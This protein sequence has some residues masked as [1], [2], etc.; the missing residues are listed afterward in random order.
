MYPN[1]SI[2][3]NSILMVWIWWI[4]SLMSVLAC[5]IP[6]V[7]IALGILFTFPSLSFPIHKNTQKFIIIHKTWRL[8][9]SQM[10]MLCSFYRCGCVLGPVLLMCK[11]W[12]VS[13][14]G[15]LNLFTIL[16]LGCQERGQLLTWHHGGFCLFSLSSPH[17]LCM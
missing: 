6:Y 7:C 9:K 12:T 8:F 16:Q 1:V 15:T 2:N 11:L 5:S 14:A 10:D 4:F 17:Q 3:W 13:E